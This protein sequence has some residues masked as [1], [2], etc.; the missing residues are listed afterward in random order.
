MEEENKSKD[1]VDALRGEYDAL[2]KTSTAFV[3]RSM[4][5]LLLP[6]IGFLVFWVFVPLTRG[7]EMDAAALNTVVSAPFEITGVACLVLWILHIHFY[8][9]CRRRKKKD[10]R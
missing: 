5:L 6:C 3:K 10:N 4:L 2:L 9:Q 7:G 8:V 1:A